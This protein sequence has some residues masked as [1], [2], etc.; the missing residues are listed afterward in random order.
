MAGRP[1]GTWRT[2]NGRPQPSLRGSGRC[3]RGWRRT[4]RRR[5]PRTR[6]PMTWTRPARMQQPVRARGPW[7]PLEDRVPYAHKVSLCTVHAAAGFSGH[8]AQTAAADGGGALAPLRE[9]TPPSASA[10]AKGRRDQG[11][12][13]G[14]RAGAPAG[15]AAAHSVGYAT[16]Y[17]RGLQLQQATVN[18][19]LQKQE[20][21]KIKRDDDDKVRLPGPAERGGLQPTADWF[22]V[23]RFSGCLAHVARSDSYCCCVRRARRCCTCR[24]LPR[25]RPCRCPR[26]WRGPPS[27]PP[28]RR[29][30]GWPRR[31]ASTA[32]RAFILTDQTVGEVAACRRPLPQLDAPVQ[33]PWLRAGAPLR[34][35]APRRAFVLARVLPLGQRLAVVQRRVVDGVTVRARVKTP[36]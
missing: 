27:M 36:L 32:V 7:T 8:R 5:R 9:C 26:A 24:P 21:K 1:C 22:A 30:P 14:A 35:Q 31:P 18:K 28:R 23:C 15:A 13:A 3:R 19:L 34:A 10:A 11:A 25:E 2:G 33:P 17:G 20:S 6:A 4:R 12:C 29:C 16:P